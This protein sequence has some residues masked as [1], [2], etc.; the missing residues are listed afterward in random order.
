MRKL[1][2][3]L[4]IVMMLAC[5]C[6]FVAKAGHELRNAKP[7]S[8][9]LN[10]KI[11]VD[12]IHLQQ[13]SYIYDKSN[14]LVAEIVNEQKRTYISLNDVPD[15]VKQIFVTMEDVRFYEHSGVDLL[16]VTRAAIANAKS[17]SIE[18][19]GST[20]T[21]Q[22]AR[23]IFL[24]HERTWDRKIRE[25]LYSYQL[26][27]NLT[28]DEILELYINAIYFQNGV[29]GIETAAN[30][31]FNRSVRQLSLAEIAFISAIPNNPTL[32]NPITQFTQ[33][34]KRQEMIL[35]VLFD[36]RLISK[37]EYNSAKE[38]TITLQ[39]QKAKDLFPDYV[40]YVYDE[41]K[42]LI[43]AKEGLTGDELQKRTNEILKSGVK[44]YTALDPKIQQTTVRALAS[45]LQHKDI[46]GAA[47]V[48]DHMRNEIVALSGGKNY[49]KFDFHRAFQAYRQPGS[50]IKPLL[51][52]GPY[53][54]L[55]GATSFSPINAGPFCKGGYC[56][57][58]YGKRTYGTVTLETALKYSYNTPAVRLLDKIG[59]HN[60]F[61]Y[62]RKFQFNR[63]T[64]EDYALPAAIGGFTKGV[65]PLELT[66]AYTTFAHDGIY[67]KAYAIRKVT[68][69]SGNVLYERP[70]EAKTIWSKKTN[71][72]MRSMLAKV[73]KEGTARKAYFP[74]TYIG[75]KTGT[76]NDYKDLWFVGLTNQYTAG[77]WVGGDKPINIQ[78]ID[79]QSPHLRIWKAIMQGV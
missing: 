67:R 34:K 37:E 20:I 47:V 77:V 23:N 32:Y 60:A 14:E 18:Q 40:T 68:D 4:L 5:F 29:Y 3:Y 48:I 45:H 26:E 16:G 24:T 30:Y 64:E 6:T 9:V 17:S 76:T 12:N 73:V 51:V 55:F 35:Q 31:Y 57:K 15:I 50:T 70:N 49:R 74:S 22:L 2:G 79:A 1:V 41:L 38:E 58:N 10:E 27:S 59:V 46:Q 13:N 61:S 71:D 66:D 19:G 56:P 7:V 53:I 39:L 36:K 44:I 62:L 72:I 69:L 78:F 33:T 42:Q 75:G 28:K 65:T 8:A 54:D 25:L 63:L 52:Y 11:Q 21:Q 43:S